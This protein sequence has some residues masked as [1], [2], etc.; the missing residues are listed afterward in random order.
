[1]LIPLILETIWLLVLGQLWLSTE[2]LAAEEA[3]QTDFAMHLAGATEDRHVMILE[4]MS[5]MFDPVIDWETFATHKHQS[6]EK[7]Y[8]QLRKLSSKDQNTLRTIGEF[9]RMSETEWKELNLVSPAQVGST[10]LANLRACI[11][12]GPLL[13]LGADDGVSIGA[14]TQSEL[15]A[16]GAARA[17]EQTARNRIKVLVYSGL[18]SNF[19]LAALLLYIFNK[20]IS[21]RLALLIDNARK[22]PL[23]EKLT[24]VVAGSDEVGYL[25]TVMHA[26]NEQ[27]C[28]ADDHRRSIMEMVAHDMRSPLMAAQVTTEVLNHPQ[29]EK[30][31]IGAK[32]LLEVVS[33]HIT[34][35]LRLVNELLIIERF[36]AGKVEFNISEFNIKDA[37]DDATLALADLS[38]SAHVTIINNCTDQVIRADKEQFEKIIINYVDSMLAFPGI[39]PTISVSTESAPNAIRISVKAPGPPLDAYLR[40]DLFKSFPKHRSKSRA[41]DLGL[42]ICKLIAQSHGGTV[43]FEQVEGSNS[44]WVRMPLN[45]NL[46]DSGQISS[47]I[48]S[49][50]QTFSSYKPTGLFGARIIHKGFALVIIPLCLEAFWIGWLNNEM[51]VGEA[52]AKKIQRVADKILSVNEG[53]NATFEVSVNAA[54]YALSG[55]PESKQRAMKQGQVARDVN[56]RLREQTRDFPT[57][58]RLVEL[59]DHAII[60]PMEMQLRITER[61]RQGLMG[62]AS[63]FRVFIAYSKA[64]SYLAATYD[65]VSAHERAEIER[66]R[67][68][69]TRSR[70]ALETTV[71]AGL[72]A[73]LILAII[74]VLVFTVHITKRLK[75]L[76][77]NAAKLPKH[78]PL[79]KGLDG[80]D[81]LAYLDFIMHRGAEEIVEAARQRQAIVE[82]L[83]DDMRSPLTLAR[84][85]LDQIE[86]LLLETTHSKA[87]GLISSVKRNIDRILQLVDDLLTLEGAQETKL[88]VRM[89]SF[90]IN[91]AVDEAIAAL[92]SIATS[93]QIQLSNQTATDQLVAD[94]S[95]VLQVLLNY[96]SNAIKFSPPHTKIEVLT[97]QDAETFRIGV[98]DQG[99]GI[100][101]E[102]QKQ[103]FEKFF[104]ANS[105]EKVRGFGLGLAICKLIAESHGGTVSVDSE[106]GHGST[107][108]LNLPIT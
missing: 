103:L 13:R 16:L 38:T 4:M 20:D 100:D 3:R 79:L 76:V 74:M 99:P 14:L 68:D 47:G 80:G 65:D 96:L 5:R 31:P 93:R 104:Q 58:Q 10:M 106:P 73:N 15:D 40:S 51:Q 30:L 56:A 84:D 39:T 107:F 72:G 27:L 55:N 50:A 41:G 54:D 29:A 1:M 7:H 59:F 86:T 61:P 75:I 2:Y 22:L 71:L 78:E 46:A 95:R 17:R 49:G 101:V 81:E 32:Q 69:Q 57:E 19:A 45:A 89:E 24:K 62:S 36:E 77:A 64:M 33:R 70:Q 63:I 97:K 66:L 102:T 25:D 105:P 43:G 18:L 42:V 23:R 85:A 52:Q 108:W 28:A 67:A 9:N 26:A 6:L 87:L 44:L 34:Q 82:L 21:G 83:V 91:A 88:N 8:E 48:K 53:L 92:A 11:R 60:R 94:R 37:V 35:V 98:R 90:E 12:L